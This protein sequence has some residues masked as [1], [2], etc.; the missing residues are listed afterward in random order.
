MPVPELCVIA[1][2]RL[3]VVDH[4]GRHDKAAALAPF[5]QW[6][7]SQL[8]L[9]PSLAPARVGIPIIVSVVAHSY[10]PQCASLIGVSCSS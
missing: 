10:I 7:A 2:M 5:A 3:G 9:T 8:W 4:L 6:A 1:F